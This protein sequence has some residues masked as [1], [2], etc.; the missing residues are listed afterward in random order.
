ME[1]ESVCKIQYCLEYNRL[2]ASRIETAIDTEPLRDC[3]EGISLSFKRSVLDPKFPYI[4]SR[5]VIKYSV[6][7]TR[8]ISA[9]VGPVNMHLSTQEHERMRRYLTGL[10]LQNIYEL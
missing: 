2:G 4:A 3:V 9:H 10:K 6:L 8:A 1:I 7:R 5:G